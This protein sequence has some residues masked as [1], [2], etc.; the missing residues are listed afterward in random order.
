MKRRL[1][2]QHK[3]VDVSVMDAMLEAAGLS[4]SEVVYEIGTGDG[5]LT[6][7]LCR[8]AAHVI[9]CE[10]DLDL[11]NATLKR[12]AQPNLTLIRGD[13]FTV[14][15]DFDILVS[16][17]P[18]S[19][20]QRFVKWL[21]EKRFKRA[22]V[23][24]QKEFVDK[25]L[26]KPGRRD[27]RAV[28]ALAQYAFDIKRI[29]NVPPS[30]FYPRPRVSSTLVVIE[31]KPDRSIG[32]D[33]QRAVFKLFSLRRKR[34]PTALRLLGVDSSLCSINVD[35]SLLSRPVGALSPDALVRLA[36]ALV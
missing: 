15:A 31:P 10:A 19:Q 30:S 6:E 35:S 23:L 11:Y 8:D 4:G 33:V 20:S 7:R 22:V 36:Q 3:L 32:R 26:A 1:L 12:L 9:S 28:S 14:E 34:L 16:S 5:T 2:G 27:Y 17:L 24:L 13:G 21:L 18:Y 29:I 25:M